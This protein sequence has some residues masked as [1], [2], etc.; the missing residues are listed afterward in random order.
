MSNQSGRD[1]QP[2][3]LDINNLSGPLLSADPVRANPGFPFPQEPI[4]SPE[5]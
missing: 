5:D 3:M 2:E 1:I 4:C